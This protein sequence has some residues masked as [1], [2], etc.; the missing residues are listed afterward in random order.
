MSDMQIKVYV[1]KEGS[2]KGLLVDPLQKYKK[3]KSVM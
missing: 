2:K 1:T 3:I